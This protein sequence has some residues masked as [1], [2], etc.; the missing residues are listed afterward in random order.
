MSVLFA[1]LSERK[2]NMSMLESFN[3][4][5]VLVLTREDC[6]SLF[7]TIE[8]IRFMC[9]MRVF[10]AKKQEQSPQETFPHFK[11]SPKPF[12]VCEPACKPQFE[13][14]NAPFFMG[15]VPR[16]KHI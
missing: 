7:G 16:P 13:N 14:P 9:A 15:T 2:F 12:G 1:Y 6:M 3:E 11:G 4:D 5:E 10:Q 8:G